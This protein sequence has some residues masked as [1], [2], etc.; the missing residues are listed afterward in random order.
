MTRAWRKKSDE[1]AGTAVAY[2]EPTQSHRASSGLLAT[3]SQTKLHQKCTRKRQ[4]Y[5]GTDGEL[6][7]DQKF[8]VV[9]ETD[10]LTQTAIVPT[11][12]YSAVWTACA[13]SGGRNALR[14]DGLGRSE[15]LRAA[16]I[17]V[18]EGCHDHDPAAGY[19]YAER[20]PCYPNKADCPRIR[21]ETKG[22]FQPVSPTLS[23]KRLSAGSA[24]LQAYYFCA[25][26]KDKHTSLGEKYIRC[27]VMT[28]LP[29]WRIAE[30]EDRRYVNCGTVIG[31]RLCETEF[32]INGKQIYCTLYSIQVPK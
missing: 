8:V 30:P 19:I 3:Y 13:I 20:D 11:T 32:S 29:E 7:L 18:R 25:A 4:V 21:V 6:G 15:Q 14:V 24:P 5:C 28:A 2:I 31:R 9:K 23:L 16:A 1:V 27:C 26:V 17:L 22:L 10:E 12:K